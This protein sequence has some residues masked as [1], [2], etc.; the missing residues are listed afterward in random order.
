MNK[1]IYAN[2]LVKLQIYCVFWGA[3]KHQK[4]NSDG[5]RRQLEKLYSV[6]QEKWTKLI[7]SKYLDVGNYFDF[8]KLYVWDKW[9]IY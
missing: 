2:I 9:K 4:I 6:I 5:Y 8:N 1:R 7:N 3:F